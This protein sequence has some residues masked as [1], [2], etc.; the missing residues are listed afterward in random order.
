MRCVMNPFKNINLI[1]YV[2]VDALR[3]LFPPWNLVPCFSIGTK[4]SASIWLLAFL[5][6]GVIG[7]TD[8]ERAWGHDVDEEIKA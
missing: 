3:L 6:V 8:G 5:F 7:F 4:Q 2:K 1:E